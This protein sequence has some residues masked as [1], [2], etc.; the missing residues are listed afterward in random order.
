MWHF[1]QTYLPIPNLRLF[2]LNTQLEMCWICTYIFCWSLKIPW[3]SAFVVKIKKIPKN[4]VLD[5]WSPNHH[6]TQT[7]IQQPINIDGPH[8]LT[9]NHACQI[10]H[11]NP[12]VTS[13][14]HMTNIYQTHVWYIFDER[15]YLQNSN[16]P[17]ANLETSDLTPERHLTDT[18]QKTLIKERLWKSLKINALIWFFDIFWL[19][20]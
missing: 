11:M 14:R 7:N 16:L 19:I 8:F 4:Y 12:L 13:Y 20:Y 1:Y 3:N 5:Y 17:I 2:S 9:L 15:K 10:S 18:W 6:L